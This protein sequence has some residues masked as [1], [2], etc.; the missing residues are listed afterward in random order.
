MVYLIC[1]LYA[2]RAVFFSTFDSS[3]W[4]DKYEHSQWKLPLSIRTLGDDGLYLYEGYRLIHGGDPTTTNA[5]VPPLGKYLIGTS[6]KLFGNG[7]WFGFL[8]CVSILF[9]FYLTASKLFINPMLAIGLTALLTVDPLFTNQYILTMVDALQSFWLLAYMYILHTITTKKYSLWHI[10]CMGMCVGFFGGTK[11][12]L[13]AGIPF[14]IGMIPLTQST[15]RVRY[16]GAYILGISIAYLVPYVPYFIYGHTLT[17]F[18]HV[19]KWT[20]SFYRNSGLVPTYGSALINLLFGSF[21]NIYSRMWQ[22][23]PFWSPVWTALCI[24]SIVL[25]LPIIK[26]LKIWRPILYL[27]ASFTFFYTIIPFWTRYLVVLLPLLYLLFGFAISRINP[28]LQS[29]LLWIFIAVNCVYSLNHFFPTPTETI[30]LFTYNWNNQFFSDM[31]EDIDKSSKTKMNRAVFQQF[32]LTTAYD[33]EIEKTEVSYSP[34]KISFFASYVTIPATITYIT[35]H[36]GPFTIHTSIPLHKEQNRWKISWDWNMYL[37]G[38]TKNTHLQTTYV[39]A[40]RGDIIA[41]DKKKLATDFS[42]VMIWVTPNKIQTNEETLLLQTLE[43]VFDRNIR[44]IY[45]HQR[46]YG[47]VLTD[48]PIPMG[49]PKHPLSLDERKALNA[50]P[51][52]SLTSHFGRYTAISD[53][54]KIGTVTNTEYFECCSQMYTTMTYDGTDGVEQKKNDQLKGINGGTLT[55]LNTEEKILQTFISREKKDGTDVEP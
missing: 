43:N 5:E 24:T 50:F 32:G 34:P 22:T 12:P 15:K 9:I 35:R 26:P 54:I 45:L 3:Y 7:Y 25:I 4:K 1:V 14:V 13:L 52:V 19:Q 37:P 6:I 38:L 53:F 42:S 27:A 28:K 36:L 40:T 8:S 55:L 11:F 44:S 20:V 39:E 33:G 46:L 10:L 48:R 29:I 16:F 51:S 18:L 23:A 30:K 49:V 31:Y 2:D 41:S 17:D 21:Q 47:N